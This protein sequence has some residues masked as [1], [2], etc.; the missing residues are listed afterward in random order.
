MAW[1]WRVLIIAAQGVGWF[2]VFIGFVNA[3]FWAY[4][5]AA[6]LILPGWFFGHVVAS[7]VE[8]LDYGHLVVTTLMGAKRRLTRED[9]G[10]PRTFFYAQTEFSQVYAPRTWI[11]VRGRWPIYLDLYGEI[12][13]RK[14]FAS[15]FRIE[16]KHLPG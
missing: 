8:L 3:E 5:V 15:V 16:R 13:D 1:F 2:L 11:P 12:P 6:P 9:L 10:K 4:L 14:A 7:Q